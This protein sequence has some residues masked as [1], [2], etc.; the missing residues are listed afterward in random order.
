M[1]RRALTFVVVG[2]G[3]AGIEALAELEDMTEDAIRYYPSIKK[4][5]MRWVLIEATDR[6]LPRSGPRWGSGPPTSSASAASS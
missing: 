1:R 2:G 5:D 4:S 6:I 3:F